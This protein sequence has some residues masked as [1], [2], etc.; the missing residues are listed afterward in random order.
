MGVQQGVLT[1]ASRPAGDMQALCPDKAVRPGGC[2]R[3]ATRHV[4]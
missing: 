1:A 4:D 2:G 3:G